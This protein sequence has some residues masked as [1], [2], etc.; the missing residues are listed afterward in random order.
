VIFLS[1]RRGLFKDTARPEMRCIMKLLLLSQS[2]KD[3]MKPSSL[4]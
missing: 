4:E 2:V 3:L 1:Q